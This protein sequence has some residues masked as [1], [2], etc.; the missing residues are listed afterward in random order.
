[1]CP[2]E[3]AHHERVARR[4]RG[5]PGWPA[6]VNWEHVQRTRELWAPWEQ[7]RLVIDTLQ[8]LDDCVERVVRRTSE[9]ARL[10]STAE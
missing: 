4:S 7:D 10:P 1:V 5:I 6:T 3:Q 9:Y 2:D 8:A